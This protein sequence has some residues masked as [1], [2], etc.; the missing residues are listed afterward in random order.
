MLRIET[1]EVELVDKRETEVM[2]YGILSREGYKTKDNLRLREKLKDAKPRG[3]AKPKSR[4]LG[5]KE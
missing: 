5:T 1:R 2:D 3:L 4:L